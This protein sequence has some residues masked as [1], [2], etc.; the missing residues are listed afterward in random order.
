MDS[1]SRNAFGEEK[2]QEGKDKNVVKREMDEIRKFISGLSVDDFKSGNWLAELAK[3]ALTNYEQKVDAGYFRKKYPDVPADAVVQARVLMAAKYAGIEGGL[4]ASAYILAVAGATGTAGLAIPAA[5]ATFAVD[6]AYTARLQLRLAYDIAVLYNTSFDLD[7]PDDMLRFVKIAFAVQ[8]REVVGNATLKGTPAVAKPL[9][10]K[11]FSGAT[12][13]AAKSLPVI[14]KYLL[15]RNIVKFAI[16]AVGV[17]LTVAVNYWM[18]KATGGNAASTMRRMA[19]INEAAD[20][21]VDLTKD[22]M[23]MLWAVWLV[24]DADGKVDGEELSLLNSLIACAR[25][26]GA[27]DDDLARLRD[28]VDV[29]ENRAWGM[30]MN[31][32]DLSSIYETAVLAAC[33]EGKLNNQEREVLRKL[34]EVCDVEYDEAYVNSILKRW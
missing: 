7:D 20:R 4:S 29:D 3:V 6:L 32:D 24:I 25:E 30:I 31:A 1:Q 13:S 9:V 16:P 23:A 27:S 15:Q 12:L 19:Q 8:G 11:I 28:T 22:Y 18:T 10:K 5:A 34:A 21:A 17:P 26:R 14:G 2:N 33:V